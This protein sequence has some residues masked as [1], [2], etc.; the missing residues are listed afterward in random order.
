MRAG[1][2]LGLPAALI[3]TLVL[4][5][6]ASADSVQVTS[7]TDDSSVVNCTLRDAIAAV[8][9]GNDINGCDPALASGTDTIAFAPG[10]SG[11]TITLIL[12]DLVIDDPAELNIVG[13]G[14]NQLTVTAADDN[15]VFTVTAGDTTSISGLSVTG[16][17]PDKESEGQGRGGGVSNQ[18]DLTLTDVRVADN[19]VN[20]I[21]SLA[22]V[23]ADGGG[24]YNAGALALDH[25]TVEGNS[26]VVGAFGS[27]ISAQ[28]RGA[29]IYSESGALSIEESTIA[30]NIATA[31]NAS[32][33]AAT[34]LAVGGMYT[35]SNFDAAH[36]TFDGNSA[37]ATLHG[38]SAATAT[39][40]GGI[41][42]QGAG[43]SSLELSTVADNLA[44][45]SSSGN[46]VATGGIYSA[47]TLAVTSSTIA[48]NGPPTG[49]FLQ[50][51]NLIEDG[52]A[53]ELTNSI[54]SDP[55]GGAG[56]N[57]RELDGGGLTS[58]GFN[59]D[60]SEQGDSCLPSPQPTDLTSNPLLATAGLSSNGGPTQTIA[61]QLSSPAIDAGLSTGA[62]DAI[63]DQRGF[64]RP[65]NFTGIPN[66]AGGNGADIGAFEVQKACP[67]Q[68]MP[69]SAC[70][71]GG[72]NPPPPPGP[73]APGPTGERAA[74]VK[75]C[76][77][78]HKG[79]AKAKKRK[80]CIKRAKRL[81]V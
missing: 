42:A 18:G 11:Q 33:G 68:A 44:A 19:L 23:S 52:G 30:D 9:A 71:S 65:V 39:T 49:A 64:I 22:N 5:A 72:G 7:N 62:I 56:L 58:G 25:S 63:H 14:M 77:K 79:K 51:A 45:L 75:K 61:L 66:A 8:T 1:R 54:F 34:A 26:A 55:R 15:R 81:P 21:S 6:S 10:L 31:D 74:A 17:D 47:T 29:G 2:L 73:P 46:N 27:I 48:R 35:A 60:F 36:S 41:L 38:P 69:T 32:S 67:S 76:K 3:T 24:I 70:P 37:T 20:A 4:A 53:L 59:I 50:G 13:P 40:A 80:K 57:C 28:A 43:A 12:G 16:G 78:K